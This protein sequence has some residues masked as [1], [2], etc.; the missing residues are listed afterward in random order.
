MNGKQFLPPVWIA[1]QKLDSQGFG[2]Q[3]NKCGFELRK[4]ELGGPAKGTHDC[5]D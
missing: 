2:D 3:R 4:E 5:P 1:T